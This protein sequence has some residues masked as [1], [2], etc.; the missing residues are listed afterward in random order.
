MT[1]IPPTAPSLLYPSTAGRRPSARPAPSEADLGLASIVRALDYDGR[2]GRF[3][4]S[5]LAELNP[6]PATIGYRQDAL[7]ELLRLPDLVA[8]CAEILP[9]I[10]ELAQ[11]GRASHW[12]EAIPLV[13]LAGRLAELEGYLTCVEGL[14]GALDAAGESLR[15]AAFLGLRA[16]LAST[17]AQPD[18]GR[19]ATELPQLRGQLDQAGSVTLGINLDGQ[20]R[21][22]SATIVAINSSRFAGK[23]TLLDRLF[24]ERAAAD[25]V[26]GITALY[27]AEDG[28]QRD[29]EH[30]LFRD[31]E[32][33]LER[34]AT[35]ISEA[36]GSYARVNGAGLAGLAPE[37]AFYLGAARMVEELRGAGLALCRPEAAPPAEQACAVAGGYSLDLALRL[38]LAAGDGALAQQIVTNEIAFDRGAAISILT[39]PN[40]GGKTTYIR[41]IGQIQTL[42][43]AGLYVP[44]RHARISPVDAIYSHFAAPER[45]DIGGGRLAE[46][47]E[48]LAQIFAQ[49][50][51]DSLLLLNEPLASTDHVAARTLCRDILAGIQMLGARAIFVTHLHELVDDVI[52]NEPELLGV[53]SLVAGI[54]AM[55]NNGTSAPEPSYTI[56]RGRPQTAGRAAEL[57][58][59]Y[60]LSR[61]Q[62]AATLRERGL[63][64]DG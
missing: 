5:V 56:T 31:L 7:D 47:L 58:R 41:A 30:D 25:T 20:L 34:V 29:P 11:A 24:G 3:V 43:Q 49:A 18:Y 48:R 45:T 27:K 9:Q 54:S 1:S 14:A 62:I 16:F 36:L 46:E 61:S 2:N 23:G 35:P 42:F 19:L 21:P 60:G 38:R 26:R 50:S 4:G 15:S 28:R 57:A 32:R 10:N 33:M 44:G 40:S 63:G 52:D 55:P 8:R 39:G 22:A 51:H 59:R 64:T 37:L 6:D 53:V 13:R 17:R 12:G